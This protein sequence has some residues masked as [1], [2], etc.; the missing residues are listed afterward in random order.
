MANLIYTNAAVE[1]LAVHFIGNKNNNGDLKLSEKE[2]NVPPD[3]EEI[4]I[5][6][7]LSPFKSDE[8]YRFSHE[9]ELPLN[10]IYSFCSSVFDNPRSFFK[11][12][13]SI[14]KHLYAQSLHPKIKEGELCIAYLSNCILDGTEGV[15]AI[16]IF[17]SESKE[18]VLR[19]KYKD[20]SYT[21]SPVEGI[22][23]NKL[24]KACLV[25]NINRGEGYKVCIHDR[26]AKTG[27]EAHYWKDSFLQV[28]L[29]SDEHNNTN[30]FLR[31][32]K[33]FIT[34]T[35]AEEQGISPT[36]QVE[37]LDRSLR[38]FQNNEVID[39]KRFQENVFE[40]P[41]TIE[42]FNAYGAAYIHAN[43]IDIS[44][45]FPVSAQALKKQEKNYRSVIKLDRNFHIYVHGNPALI[46][47]GTE[48]DGRKYYKIYY[49]QEQ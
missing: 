25:F 39:T 44:A 5:N 42:A 1:S 37:L 41:N 13:Q 33:S 28:T 12:S 8:Y 4:F 21:V 9:S 34:K 29:L 22:S 16:A 2:T 43:N 48:S 23:I 31:L 14:A 3:A 46:E 17:K 18:N 45:E 36:E 20:G 11:S 35:L 15:D 10:E 30:H 32:T 7:F 24:D 38:F 26:A 27:E 49:E 47:R 6:Y 40:D 19:T